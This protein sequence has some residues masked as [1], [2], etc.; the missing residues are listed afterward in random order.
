VRARL[1]LAALLAAAPLAAQDNAGAR[2]QALQLFRAGELLR[3]HV[4]GVGSLRG[5][6]VQLDTA[7][8]VVRDRRTQRD[9]PITV[10][11]SIWR[12][13]NHRTRGTAVGAITGMVAG[14]IMGSFL[15]PTACS[16]ANPPTGRYVVRGAVIGLSFGAVIGTIAGGVV[17]RWERWYP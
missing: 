2:L 11:D 3:L 15:G 16:C 13:D 8:L 17:T 9:I 1:V 7:T 4:R 5:V 12:R 6:F 10:I 14:G